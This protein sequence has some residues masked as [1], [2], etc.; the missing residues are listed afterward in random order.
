MI[1]RQG[2]ELSRSHLVVGLMAVLAGGLRFAMASA[3]AAEPPPPKAA[4]PPRQVLRPGDPHAHGLSDEDLEAMRAILRQAVHDRVVPGVSLLLAHK[5]E[6]IFKEAFGDLRLDQKVQMASSSKPVTA[7]LLMILVDQ[8]KLA[9]DDPIEKY[10]PEFQRITLHGKPPARR[11]TVRHLLSNMSGLPGDLLVG[12][13][14][15]RL[16][17][18]AGKA[19]G[20]D[21]GIGGVEDMKKAR[22]QFFASRNRSLAESVRAL[23]EGGLATEP[24]AAFH[25]CT[26]GFNVAA[27]VA[28]VAARQP[29]EELVRAELLAPLGMND[30]R[31]LS[32]GLQALRPGPTLPDGQSRFIMAGGGMTATLDDFAAFYQMHL[33]G[34]TYRGRRILSERA[35]AEMHTRQGKLDLLMAGPYGNDY[36]LAFFLD[37]LD[38]RG[39][40]RVITHPGFFGTTPWLDKDRE[41]VGVLF[42]Q[43]H[44]LRVI[45]LVH[46]VQEKARAVVPVSQGGPTH[47]RAGADSSSRPR[48]AKSAQAGLEAER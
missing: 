17:D 12:S 23:A 33:N 26:M 27:R 11:P 7:T 9:L 3:C 29:F 37:R 25:Y 4:S 22:A 39:R 20:A 14:L 5:G 34:G 48:R 35:V 47:P 6:V 44:F 19:E 30:T 13:I 31:Y 36:G 15:R 40:A 41:L 1:I 18:R 16:R 32:F 10:L 8:G 38:D 46:R 42:V 45:P 24:G 21:P 43:S 2:L 28:E